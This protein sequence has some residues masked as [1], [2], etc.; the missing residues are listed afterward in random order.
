MSG[1]TR[2]AGVDFPHDLTSLIVFVASRCDRFWCETGAV[3]AT[4]V[5]GKRLEMN[6]AGWFGDAPWRRTGRLSMT[7][8]GG[9][10][11][12]RNRWPETLGFIFVLRPVEAADATKSLENERS[13]DVP[14]GILPSEGR[15]HKFESCRA[16]Q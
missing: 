11:A 10:L 2:S 4:G 14:G 13:H 7:I 5:R 16:R 1:G 3:I 12:E 8:V 6:F 9:P 15:G